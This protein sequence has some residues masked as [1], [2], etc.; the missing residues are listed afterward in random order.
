[1]ITGA[2]SG[3]GKVAAMVLARQGAHVVIHGRDAARA[4]AVRQEIMVACG[5]ERVDVLVADLF[6]QADVQRVANAFLERY[7]RLDV[8]I[9]NAGCLM[10]NRREVTKE[11][12]ECTLAVNLFAPFLLTALLM[13]A[14]KRS[15]SARV[16]NVSSSAHRQSARPDFTDLQCERNYAPLRAYGNA[17]LFLI[18]VSQALARGL[19]DARIRTITVNTLHPGVV[20][21]NF[22]V[23]SDLGG[24]L[25]FIGRIVRPF[26]KTA[27]RGADTIIFLASSPEVEGITGSYFINRKPAP[28]AAR[29]NTPENERRIVAFCEQYTGAA[30]L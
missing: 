29:Y 5:H 27:E 24:V 12:Y 23:A 30:L 4:A 2:T 21:S 8:L 25:N 11:G 18:L 1:M 22:S 13:P 19:A 3:I 16:I 9:N 15:A 20:S 28:V 14:L 6:L 17:K 7:D 26:M 10:G